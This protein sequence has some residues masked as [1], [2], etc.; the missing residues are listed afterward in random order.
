[1]CSRTFRSMPLLARPPTMPGIASPIPQELLQ[2]LIARAGIRG[3]E[4]LLDLA[5]GPGRVALA[6]AATFREVWAIDREAEMIEVGQHEAIQRNVHNITWMVG[7]AEDLA[8]PPD[9]FALVHHRGSVPPPRS[10]A[11]GHAHPAAVVAGRLCG[12]HG[13]LWHHKWQGTVAT[14]CRGDSPTRDEPHCCARR[15][16]CPAQA[17]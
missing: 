14:H 3:E 7:Q 8:A 11:C 16:C 15:R 1:M 9:S 10:A 4:R 13:M 17:G 12:H 5:C 6:L 2:D